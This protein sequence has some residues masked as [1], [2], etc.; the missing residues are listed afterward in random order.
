M[1]EEVDSIFIE[2]EVP[3]S[4]NSKEIGYF[5]LKKGTI[6]KIYVLR[7]GNMLPVRLNLRSSNQTKRYIKDSN[8]LYVAR[9]KEFEKL[10]EGLQMPFR[11]KF[12][13]HRKTR[14]KFDYINAAQIV[15]DLMVEHGWIED[16]N[17]ECLIPYFGE[18]IH[19]KENPGVKISIV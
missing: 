9:R 10:V 2:G 15:Q 11:V 12:T 16:D 17:C 7:N 1:S 13:F 8:I 19:D 4:K 3:S 14:R 5:F 18:W 6:G